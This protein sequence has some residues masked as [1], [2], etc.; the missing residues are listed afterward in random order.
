VAATNG[1]SPAVSGR[2]WVCD[3]P[4]E[5]KRCAVLPVFNLAPARR[6]PAFFANQPV[7]NF[8]ARPASPP[9][10]T[11]GEATAAAIMALLDGPM[12][13]SAAPLLD[14][15]EPIPR[16]T[17]L[18]TVRKARGGFTFT[19]EFNFPASGFFFLP[20]S[21]LRLTGLGETTGRARLGSRFAYVGLSEPRAEAL[22]DF[23]AVAP[24]GGADG[25]RLFVMRGTAVFDPGGRDRF[26]FAAPARFAFQS[27]FTFVDSA[28]D[29]TGRRLTE[30]S[31]SFTF[32]SAAAVRG[33]SFRIPGH[34]ITSCTGPDGTLCAPSGPTASSKNRFSADTSFSFSLVTTPPLARGTVVEMT[35]DTDEGPAGTA[36]VM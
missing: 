33:L 24:A 21:D 8:F 2:A 18:N 13:A 9:R 4:G 35:V 16:I 11:A 32:S 26:R 1:R 17:R 12:P 30:P 36:D 34:T 15:S 31:A 3:A 22:F 27:I 25:G 10:T 6:L 20:A 7:A 5:E 29:S 23:T 28:F 14:S 19:P